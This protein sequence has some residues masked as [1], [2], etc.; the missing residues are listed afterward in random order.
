M[1]RLENATNLA[2]YMVIHCTSVH[3]VMVE[4]VMWAIFRIYDPHFSVSIKSLHEFL[5]LSLINSSALY[6]NM[7][8]FN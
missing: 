1:D 2:K 3:I 7:D 8:G 4:N 5:K 6:Y